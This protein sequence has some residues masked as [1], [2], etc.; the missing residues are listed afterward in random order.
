MWKAKHVPADGSK[1]VTVYRMRFEKADLNEPS[2]WVPES[3]DAPNPTAVTPKASVAA[4]G[5]C[6]TPSKEMFTAGWFCLN[7]R[8]EH[9]YVFPDGAAV[10]PKGLTYT[11]AFINERTAFVGEVPSVIPAIPDYSGLHGTELAMRRGLVCPDCGCCNRRVYWN[12]WEC[13]NKECQYV[14]V[15]PM[16]PYPA[17]LLKQENE[18]FDSSMEGKRNKHGVNENTLAQDPY[19]LDPFATIYQRGY[20]QFSQTLTLGGYEVRQ[21]FFPDSQGTILGSFS[22]FSAS[23][24]VNCRPDGPDDLFRMLEFTDIGLRR[25]P[26]ATIGRK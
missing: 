12:R 15:A 19:P 22:I 18:E 7:H 3:A 1:A 21:Y 2:W 11:E 4:C 25:N 10:D 24:E 9:Y 14:L 20:L 13:D 26:A 6:E 5:K 17:D 23:Q 8:C 16:L